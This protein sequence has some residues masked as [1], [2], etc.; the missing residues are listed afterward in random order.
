M[1][2]CAEIIKNIE[3][4]V[5]EYKKVIIAKTIGL[6]QSS[7]CATWIFIN[8]DRRWELRLPSDKKRVA[9]PDSCFSLRDL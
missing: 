1:P 4:M 5:L 8:E 9:F 6:R 2:I 3:I 7:Y